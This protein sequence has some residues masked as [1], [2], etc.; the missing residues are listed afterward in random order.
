MDE[1]LY[2]MT[3][4]EELYRL[5]LGLRICPLDWPLPSKKCFKF[6][7]TYTTPT[8]AEVTPPRDHWKLYTLKYEDHTY[9]L[10]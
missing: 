7:N 1:I 3:E 5:K 10:E 8:L 6:W 2:Y 9:L 4:E